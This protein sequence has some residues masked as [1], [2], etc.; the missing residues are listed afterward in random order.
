MVR[1]YILPEVFLKSDKIRKNG[2]G[3]FGMRLFLLLEYLVLMCLKYVSKSV[4]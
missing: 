2:L 3:S 4:L 1:V